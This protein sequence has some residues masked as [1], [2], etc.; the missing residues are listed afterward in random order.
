[1]PVRLALGLP[2]AAGDSSVPSEAWKSPPPK[3]PSV[4]NK[5][6]SAST[7]LQLH[8]STV[9]TQQ[10]CSCTA[11]FTPLSGCSMQCTSYYAECSGSSSATAVLTVCQV[12]MW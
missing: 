1:M 2:T 6:S 9:S 10:F 11:S 12:M 7:V 5:V 8:Y 3:R 4:D